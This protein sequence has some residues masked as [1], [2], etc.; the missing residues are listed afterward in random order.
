[1][2]G[3]ALKLICENLGDR[4]LYILEAD[5][6]MK[7]FGA[8]LRKLCGNLDF[9][10]RVSE[11]IQTIKLNLEEVKEGEGWIVYV[12][13][14]NNFADIYEY[15]KPR[16]RNRFNVERPFDVSEK[17]FRVGFFP[18]KEE[19]YEFFLNISKILKNKEKIKFDVIYT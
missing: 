11:I 18:S 15:N 19:A 1:M 4:E 6:D 10:A 13:P 9:N 14:I 5:K 7:W 8:S 2:W 3:R 12:D 17:G 16:Y